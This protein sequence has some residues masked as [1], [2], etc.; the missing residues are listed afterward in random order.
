MLERCEIAIEQCEQAHF[1]AAMA[2]L[3]VVALRD[4]DEDD[5][6][7]EG[8]GG[9]GEGDGPHPDLSASLHRVGEAALRLQTAWDD[10]NAAAWAEV[11]NGR[12]VRCGAV[13]P[14]NVY[15]W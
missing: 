5:E 1:R 12:A 10:W 8:G 2:F 6:D 14:I 4:D 15:S 13:R 9:R 7:V 11:A 3:H